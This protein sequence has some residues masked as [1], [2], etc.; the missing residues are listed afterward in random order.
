MAEDIK[1]CA[2]CKEEVPAL[3][4]QGDCPICELIYGIEDDDLDEEDDDDDYDI[5]KY[6]DY[7]T[8]LNSKPQN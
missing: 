8:S 5:D 4:E 1:T 6:I 3:N 7:L 2:T